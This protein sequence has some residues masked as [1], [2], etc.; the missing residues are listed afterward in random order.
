MSQ[1]LNS[2]FEGVELASS[3]HRVTATAGVTV[4]K[5]T[6][7]FRGLMNTELLSIATGYDRIRGAA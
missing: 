5:Q 1:I 4:V 7:K 3:L 6:A 2:T